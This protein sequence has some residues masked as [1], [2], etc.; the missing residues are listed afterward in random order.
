M[1]E[2]DKRLIL[3][4]IDDA[5]GVERFNA[6]M[7]EKLLECMRLTVAA[8][9]ARGAHQRPRRSGMESRLQLQSQSQRHPRAW[10]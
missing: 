10:Q 5:M 1:D 2:G 4:L 8:V 9:V 6:E 7:Q 3:G